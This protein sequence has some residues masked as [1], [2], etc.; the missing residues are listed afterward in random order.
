MKLFT[1]A[2]GLLLLLINCTFQAH[3]MARVPPDS[4]IHLPAG[5]ARCNQVTIAWKSTAADTA[6]YKGKRSLL[7]LQA[8]STATAAPEA[9]SGTSY[10][11]SSF[12]GAGQQLGPGQFVVY[13][14]T[15]HVATI[16]GLQPN[17]AYRADVIAYYDSITFM[18]GSLHYA[19][20]DPA[21]IDTSVSLYFT[22][23]GCST[24]TPPTRGASGASA[25]VIDCSTATLTVNR[26]NGDGRLMVI[27]RVP[28]GSLGAFLSTEPQSGQFYFPN[29]LY[30]RG[31]SLGPDAYA[32]AL[33]ADS[34]TTLYGLI[35]GERYKFVAYEYLNERDGAGANTNANPGYAAPVD[36]AYFDVPLCGTTE[37]QTAATNLVQTDT[38]AT[39]IRI[40]WTNGSGTGRIVVLSPL[41]NIGGL[42]LPT[43]NTVYPAAAFGQG[44]QTRPGAFVVYNGR[45]SAATITNL[46]PDTYYQAQ[47]YEY[48]EAADGTPTYLLSQAPAYGLVKTYPA[49]AAVAPSKIR[50]H[51]SEPFTYYDGITL[52]SWKPGTGTHY[53]IL[54]QEVRPGRG[55]LFQPVDGTFY[56]QRTN[57]DMTPASRLSGSTYLLSRKAYTSASDTLIYLRNASM[58]HEYEMAVVEYVLDGNGLPVYTSSTPMNFRTGRF[59]PSLKGSLVNNEPNL[60]FSVSAQYHSDYFQIYASEDNTRFTSVGTRIPVTQDSVMSSVSLTQNLSLITVPT[61]YRVELHHRDGEHVYSNTLLLTPSK[62]L[63]VELIRFTGRLG[64]GNQA[65]L[66]WAT[67]SEKNS[68]YFEVERSTDGQRFVVAGRAN[69]AGTSTQQRSYELLDPQPISQLT[70]YR[71]HQVDLDGSNT[72]SSVITLRPGPLDLQLSVWPNPATT[73]QR[74]QLRL[75]G[76]RELASPVQVTIRSVLGQVVRQQTLAAAPVVDWSWSLAGYSPGLYLVEVQ[77]SAGRQVQR[78]QVQ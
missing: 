34:T 69:A 2:L 78:L 17:T 21:V 32:V 41:T 1:K 22:T 42:L 15:G 36:T 51:F 68:A 73:G 39:T 31:Q 56:N 27:Q 37:P 5:M 49:P 70:Y 6:L 55:P 10:I 57:N 35:P 11:P 16:S 43:Q 48:N 8:V 76:L 53:L 23:P 52:I 33:G 24:S 45:D 46:Q 3:G 20:P 4:A 61:Y 74:A 63:P 25:N 66:N 60:R 64:A 30:G 77:T 18:M 7:V 26:G 50:F 9:Q 44:G 40:T 28:S 19:N 71:L 67:A 58:G 13:A 14:D 54:A 29:N 65:T 47:V 62:P 38:T 75:S 12:F 59:A 72:Y